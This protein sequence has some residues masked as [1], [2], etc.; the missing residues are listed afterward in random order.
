MK[1][2]CVAPH[3]TFSSLYPRECPLPE[4]GAQH[5]YTIFEIL[6]PVHYS[7]NQSNVSI[8]S[9]TKHMCTHSH[10]LFSTFL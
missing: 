7:K 9:P 8:S 1:Y 10:P 2:L 5:P 6:L 4:R 3:T